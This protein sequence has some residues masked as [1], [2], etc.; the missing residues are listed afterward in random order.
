MY[1]KKSTSHHTLSGTSPIP[2]LTK[3]DFKELREDIKRNRRERL[4]FVKLYADWVRKNP[5][6][7][8]SRAQNVLINR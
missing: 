4:E 3:K 7:V 1:S 6:K 5:N 8:W 2:R